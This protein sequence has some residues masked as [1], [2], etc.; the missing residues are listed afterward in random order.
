MK[1][2]DIRTNDPQ[3]ARLPLFRPEEINFNKTGN[4]KKEDSL[5]IEKKSSESSSTQWQ[6]EILLSA[7]DDLENNIQDDDNHPLGKLSNAPI[8]TYDEALIEL[9]FLKTPKFVTTA[10]EAQANL[11]ADDVMYLFRGE[12]V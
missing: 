6:K 4:L 3:D 12:A 5:N 10:S 11:T 7:L 2:T 9:S 8:E 1:I